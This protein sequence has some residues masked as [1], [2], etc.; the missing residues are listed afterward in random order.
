MTTSKHK[1]FG[2]WLL[3]CLFAAFSLR[4][5]AQVM[6]SGQIVT[7]TTGSTVTLLNTESV[8]NLVL[9]PFTV[10]TVGTLSGCSAA[11]QV[12]LFRDGIQV[13]EVTMTNGISSW[14]DNGPF[15]ISY[16]SDPG[17]PPAIKAVLV[18]AGA[19]CTNLLPINVSVSYEPAFGSS[20]YGTITGSF[21]TSTSGR[22]HNAT[23][24]FNLSQPA[25]LVWHGD[26]RE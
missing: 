4:A 14:S 24:T 20:Q 10:S 16:P 19:G 23:L 1:F 5:N 12:G 18:T 13:G 26:F 6:T 2:L 15:G 25:V 17:Y 3:T 8:P 11:P 9:P 7:N 22:V 21:Q